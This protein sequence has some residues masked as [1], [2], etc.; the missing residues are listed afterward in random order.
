MKTLDQLQ[1]M[2]I[3]TSPL[4]ANEILNL[5]AENHDELLVLKELVKLIK[6]EIKIQLISDI[7][8]RLRN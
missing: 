1:K 6:E 4:T 2:K 3:P 5:A 7:S 8:H